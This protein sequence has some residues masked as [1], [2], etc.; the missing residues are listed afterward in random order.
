MNSNKKIYPSIIIN[1]NIDNNHIIRINNNDNMVNETI[2]IPS[3]LV[4]PIGNNIGIMNENNNENIN[5]NT[6]RTCF[7]LIL[8]FFMIFLGFIFIGCILY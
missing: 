6:F 7:L 8:F 5:N 4:T 2:F 1:N 3:E